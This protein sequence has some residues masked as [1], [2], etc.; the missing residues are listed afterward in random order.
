[1]IVVSAGIRPEVELAT[2]MGVDVERG[3]VVDDAMRTNVPG[4]WAVGECAQHDGVVQG[5]W[6]PI[7]EQA[8]V[9]GATVTCNPAGFH[10]ALPVTRL[11]VAEIELFCAGA[12]SAE[13]PDDD[14]IVVMNTRI[15]HYRKLVVRDDR[16]VGAIL[17]GDTALGGRLRE[18]IR[19]GDPVPPHLL[20][21]TPMGTA[22]AEDSA[23]TLVC[24]CNDVSRGQILEAVEKGG[25]TH[26]DQVSRA[27]G[28]STGCGTCRNTVTALLRGATADASAPEE[29]P[30]HQL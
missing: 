5:L 11:K 22:M 16:L 26:V 4:V 25:L 30:V 21:A 13:E 12:H 23:D 6:A 24:A 29:R 17:L 20:D 15:G 1:M 3:I 2:A 14:E 27:T 7:R 18:L 28:A 8:K 9:A 19:T 10:G